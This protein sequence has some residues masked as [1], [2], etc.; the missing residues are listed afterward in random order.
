M[1]SSKT[2]YLIFCESPYWTSM[3]RGL[4][5]MDIDNFNFFSWYAISYFLQQKCIQVWII[6]IVCILV[7]QTHK[8][9]GLQNTQCCIDLDLKVVYTLFLC[10][11]MTSSFCFV[12]FL[13]LGV[14]INI[15]S[16]SY[17]VTQTCISD[18]YIYKTGFTI[19]FN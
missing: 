2:Y 9:Y 6:L 12:L 8:E 3:C 17:K 19:W 18:V 7:S 14:E 10:L 4:S 15:D 11:M 5:C 16:N 1:K 13:F